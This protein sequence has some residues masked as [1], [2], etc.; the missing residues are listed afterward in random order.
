MARF[1]HFIKPNHTNETPQHAVWFDTE[2][3]QEDIGNDTVSHHLDFGW[4]AY[5]RRIR[6]GR[7]SAPQWFRFET[8]G[9]FYR[10]LF[11]LCRPRTRLYAFCHNTA[12]DLPVLD[13]FNQLPAQG[14]EL[15]RAVIDA[16][17]TILSWRKDTT[18]IL[19][20][21]TLNI[22]RMPLAALGDSI[23]LPKLD[24]PPKG[25]SRK[26]WDRYGRRDVEVIMEA[27]LRW[28]Q[29]LI[30]WNMGGFA[31]TLAAQ[32]L[33]TFRHAHMDH[34]IFIDNDERALGV[35]RAAY[36]GARTE[37]FYIGKATG[38][39]Y[40][41][42]V[43]S[44]YPG[45]MK[46]N[47]YPTI[48]QTFTRR[49]S[50]RDLERWCR[51]RLLVA[52]VMIDTDEPAY[53]VQ[54]DDKLMF[55]TGRFKAHV[56]TPDILYALARGH[57]RRVDAVALYAKAP[58]FRS[59][60]TA[61]YSE[62]L[63]ARDRGD[64]VLAWQLKILLNSLYGK[65]G[66]R[67]FVFEPAGSTPELDARKWVELDMETGKR[68]TWRRLAGLVQRQEKEQEA[69]E[70]MP[71]I[72][73]HVTAYARR[74]L[75]EYIKQAGVDNVFYMDTD[76][77]L[78]NQEGR[79]RLADH[80]DPSRLGMLKEE[81]SY[82]DIEIH[83]PK[84]YRFGNKAKTKGVRKSAEWVT[85]NKVRQEKWSSLRGLLGAGDL[86]APTTATITKTLRRVY[87][88]GVVGDDGRVSPFVLGD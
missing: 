13:V 41:L 11:T 61:L 87:N 22:W 28:W 72:A 81:D 39:F 26:E 2:T 49:A 38:K 84:D 25:A 48:L 56:T 74:Q 51:D 80:I 54:R 9:E 6:G 36:H 57:I 62:R 24:M 66:Q 47:D 19:M 64:H 45:V 67:G 31:N 53:A 43:N 3:N 52:E 17:P 30:D 37:C 78:V 10:W 4:A 60:V 70:S 46:D 44:Q 12:F 14:W 73:A 71:A 75:W 20:L 35:A 77:L 5:R 29:M 16:P 33:R 55:P 32:S 27:C 42:D 18:S 76:G 21:D 50:V 34:R 85:S 86:T 79:D 68:I 15:K 40:L 82:T 63:A 7:W 1:P 83:G 23:G 8:I 65:F 88:K 69:R 58:V 59:F